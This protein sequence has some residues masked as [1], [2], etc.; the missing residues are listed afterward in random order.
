LQNR[1]PGGQFLFTCSDT[2]AARCI[3]YP[4]RTTSQTDGSIIPIVDVGL[5]RV[6]YYRLKSKNQSKPNGV[7]SSTSINNK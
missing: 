2:S 4:Q 3:V 1:F 5:L 7:I 6:V